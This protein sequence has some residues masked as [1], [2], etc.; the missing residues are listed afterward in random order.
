M[1]VS[2]GLKVVQAFDINEVGKDAGELAGVGKIGV[3]IQEDISKLDADVLIDFTTAEAAIRN[4]EVAAEKGVRV[5]MGTTGFTDEDRKRLAELAK[6]VPMIISPNF[7]LGVNVFWKIV[8]YA[9]RM[10]YEWDAEIVEYH[11]RHKRDSPSGTALKLAEIIKKAK[12]GKGLKADL[13]TCREGI[14]PRESEI[15][16]FGVRGGDVVGEHTV[17]FF[18][19]GERV[20]LTHRATRQGVLCKGGC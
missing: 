2:E 19:S 20:E 5:V 1:Q 10:L 13:K 16:V 3:P 4:A 17:F 9:A 7:S 8:E 15:G 6:K 11:H 14:S 18:G 12:E